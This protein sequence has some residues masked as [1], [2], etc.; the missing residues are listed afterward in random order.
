MNTNMTGFKCFFKN[1]YALVLREKVASALKGL[2]WTASYRKTPLH[3]NP[4][5]T[6]VVRDSNQWR[7]I[8]SKFINASARVLNW[9]ICLERQ[10]SGKSWFHYSD[11][12]LT[13]CPV[14]HP[15]MISIFIGL[16]W[17]RNSEQDPTTY[18]PVILIAPQER[19]GCTGKYLSDLDWN[20]VFRQ[21]FAI[22]WI[23]RD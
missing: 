18:N 11:L 5:Y 2:R 6:A 8:L 3:R 9:D 1:L 19:L 22:L 20:F 15:Y 14:N 7:V 12:S 10:I 17:G 16:S 21:F 13:W 23:S 4:C